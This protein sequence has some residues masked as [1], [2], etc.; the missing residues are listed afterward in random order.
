[1]NDK[2][3]SKPGGPGATGLGAGGPAGA[4]SKLFEA[5]SFPMSTAF[6]Q[7]GEAYTQ[8]FVEW[9]QEL[10]RFTRERLEKNRELHSQLT[11]CRTMGEVAKVQQDWALA[12]ARAYIDEANQL[13]QVWGK[14]LQPGG[15]KKG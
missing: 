3:D 11:K 14:L 2:P 1:M 5:W 9:Q 15:P 6:W 10:G 13:A 12:A 8:A 4:A 7:T